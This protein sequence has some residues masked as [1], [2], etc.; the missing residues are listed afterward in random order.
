[1]CFPCDCQVVITHVKS[2]VY[3]GKSQH[4]ELRLRQLID[5]VVMSL[6]FVKPE[7]NFA[8]SLTKPPLFEDLMGRLQVEDLEFFFV[9]C[10]VLWNQRNSVVHGGCIQD[11]ARLVQCAKDVLQEYQDAQTQLSAPIPSSSMQQ[12]LRWVPPLGS[13]YKLN[14]DVAV[15]KGMKASGY[16]AVVWND[17]GEV[18]A[19][20]AGKGPQVQDSEEAEVLA[21]RRAVEFAL[22]A[23]F[24]EI[25][26]EGDNC[27]VMMAILGP[28]P[29]RDRLGHV[30]EDIKTM[31]REFRAFSVLCVKRDAN[32]VAHSLAMF[33][34][35]ID[36]E[37]VW[38]E[39]NPPPAAD[40]L[41]FDSCNLM[42]E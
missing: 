35:Q 24:R 31:G 19:A 20:M 9:Q 14:V 39:E 5:N 28:K 33:A 8:N 42:N 38:L 25:I 18:M 3:N 1:M 22:E 4:I 6:D 34:R 23:G 7:R 32:S 30:N 17:K 11:P 36:G 2:K 29:D 40:A 26:L 37:I 15:F 13:A 16:G 41:Y 21:C 12:Q 10:W 27:T